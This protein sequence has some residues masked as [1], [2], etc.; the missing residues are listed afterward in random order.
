MEA[1]SAVTAQEREMSR[2]LERT[3]AISEAA[4]VEFAALTKV[5]D[6]LL[7]GATTLAEALS[8]ELPEMKKQVEEKVARGGTMELHRGGVKSSGERSDMWEDEEQQH[9][10][11]TLPDLRA[12]IPAV[13]LVNET[14]ENET[15]AERL[16]RE[17]EEN[18]EGRS[19]KVEGLI[20]RLSDSLSKDKADTICTDFCYIAARG[21]R[22]RLIQE[23]LS[24]HRSEVDRIP[25]YGR[26]IATLANV[27]D[28]IAPAVSE[29]LKNEFYNLVKKGKRANLSERL[30]NIKF[31]GELIKF[32]VFDDL[33][34]FE[35]VKSLL[36]DFHGDNVDVLC[37][38]FDV[39]GYYLTRTPSTSKRMG[40]IL[41]IFLRLKAV[42]KLDSRQCALVDSAYYKC[43]PVQ[44]VVVEKIRPPLHEYIRELIYLQL[45]KHTLD[46]VA[47]QLRK[48]PW[49]ETEPYLLKRLLK[50]SKGRYASVPLV[51][52]LIARLSQYY[53]TLAVRALDTL[54]EDIRFGLETNE[55]WMHQRRVANMRLLAL[56]YKERVALFRELMDTLYLIIS[57]GYDGREAPD[58]L[59]DTIRL[60]RF[61][62][63]WKPRSREEEPL[64][65]RR[66]KK[67]TGS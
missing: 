16:K 30:K 65:T 28:D 35:I 4:S 55:T 5:F 58:Y 36:D 6:G 48:L 19:A 10:Y 17:R 33:A 20:M 57:I 26:I 64:V 61:V 54:L 53:P 18:A 38:L 63:F 29:P 15:E 13:L 51:A 42:S 41:D 46:K 31:I 67:S 2:S 3:G 34:V 66:R 60:R 23:F 21:G 45:S 25:F 22:R 40:S 27:F 9:F 8:R 47:T 52:A 12:S 14:N 62:R 32:K 37:C 50:V 11:E 49:D 39:A 44:R 56:L 24:V 43:R 1:F 59:T 7:K